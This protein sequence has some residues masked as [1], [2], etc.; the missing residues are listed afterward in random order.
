[1]KTKIV[2]ALLYFGFALF[3][4]LEW[5]SLTAASAQEEV[6]LAMYRRLQVNQTRLPVA[7]P[8]QYLKAYAGNHQGIAHYI[9]RERQFIVVSLALTLPIAF[10]LLAS[11]R[12][13][14]MPNHFPLP[15]PSAAD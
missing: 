10:Y 5:R 4:A 6:A 12:P 1:M 13:K 11:S 14:K 9:G 7:T 2:L 3:A 8:D 15:T